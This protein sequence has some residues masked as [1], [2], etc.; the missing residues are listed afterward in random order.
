MTRVCVDIWFGGMGSS[1]PVG[2]GVEDIDGR[3]QHV[4]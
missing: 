2:A 4:G 1:K 3:R